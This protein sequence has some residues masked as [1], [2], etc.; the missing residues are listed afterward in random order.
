[1]VACIV[2]LDVGVV[3]APDLEAVSILVTGVFL[4]VL[5]HPFIEIGEISILVIVCE[6]CGLLRGHNKYNTNDS[7]EC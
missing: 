6:R 7:E 5:E 3:V 4:F 2:F 1:V